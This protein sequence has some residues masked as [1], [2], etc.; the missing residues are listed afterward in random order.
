MGVVEM[1]AEAQRYIL[2]C[3]G[4]GL[5]AIGILESE[6][7]FL[8]FTEKDLVKRRELEAV[9]YTINFHKKPYSIL[10]YRDLNTGRHEFIVD[11]GTKQVFYGDLEYVIKCIRTQK[12]R[13]DSKKEEYDQAINLVKKA[14]K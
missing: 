3:S 2:V 9:K 10:P 1:D 12:E 11:D 8:K 4:A 14:S 5:D 13:L 6:E 7:S